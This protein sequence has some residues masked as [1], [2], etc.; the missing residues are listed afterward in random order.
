MMASS[1]PIA[2]PA[3]KKVSVQV[4]PLGPVLPLASRCA[5][6]C[7]AEATPYIPSDFLAGFMEP[8]GLSSTTNPSQADLLSLEVQ[9]RNAALAQNDLF[10]LGLNATPAIETAS[11]R[12]DPFPLPGS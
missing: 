7:G 11:G 10:L 6:V 8:K 9:L 3:G 4:T 2:V 1:N 5:G 12:L